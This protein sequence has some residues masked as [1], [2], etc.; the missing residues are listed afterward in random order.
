MTETRRP[1]QQELVALKG[2]TLFISE[3]LALF[4]TRLRNHQT[5]PVILEAL[6]EVGLDTVPSFTTCG[7]RTEMLIVARELITP[8]A[9]DEEIFPGTLP[10]QPFRIGDIPSA[11]AGVDSVSSSAP[12]SHATHKM[13]QKN[14]SQLPVIDGTSDLKG[15]VTWS[16]IAARYEKG[17]VPSLA[18]AMVRDSIPVAEVHQE[19]IPHLP[20]VAEHG[21]LLVRSNS[22]SIDGIITGADIIDRFD[23]IARPFFL[24]GEIESRL[25]RCLGPKLTGSP[26][27]AV[28]QRSRQTG[29]ISDL[30]F[31]EYV[32]LLDVDQN[33]QRLRACA[34]DNW[35]ALGW[36]GVNRAQFVYQL[37]Q[38][39]SIRNQI[40]HFDDKPLSGQ[41]LTALNEF[42]GLLKQL[43]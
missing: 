25:R 35:R 38:V 31:G 17:V 5:V 18:N 29:D 28:Q 14:Y 16:S 4:G 40:A 37:K 39:K 7:I 19:L 6:R 12:L 24:V 43:L 9:E 41:Q 22:G 30:M 36:A 33:D 1:T 27:R 23:A 11:R 42:S 2:T 34:D 26:V 32:K 21:Y 3:L 13:R 15:V 8:A 20:V 10:Q